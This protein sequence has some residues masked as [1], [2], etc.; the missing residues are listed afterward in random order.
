MGISFGRDIINIG[1][2]K[3]KVKRS[4]LER[5]IRGAIIS[6]ELLWAVEDAAGYVI[7]TID[8]LERMENKLA[9]YESKSR[10]LA[11][12]AELNN[13]GIE[14]EKQGKIDAAIA[15]YEQNISGDCY[16]A[17]HSFDRLRILYRKRKDYDNM[18]RVIKREGEVFGLSQ[19]A[20]NDK[21]NRYLGVKDGVKADVVYPKVRKVATVNGDT[22]ETKLVDI[23]NRLPE[24]DFY[25]KVEHGQRNI[26]PLSESRKLVAIL[27]KIKEKIEKGAE[28]ERNGR[29]DLAA[30][31]YEELVA[32][33]VYNTK[34]Y[35]RLVMIYKR[36]KLFD[37]S[38]SILQA[39]IEFF[40]GLRK[41]QYT[42][43]HYLADKYGVRSING[44]PID[45]YGKIY[46]YNGLFELY[47]PY[48]I[49]EK[50]EQQLEAQRNSS[51]K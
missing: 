33:H 24:F 42:K 40:K 13:K 45:D 4:Y 21:I 3:V 30:K 31:I 37:D 11:R 7:T 44:V 17:S 32:N 19:S 16:P 39:S 1:G 15:I 50:W 18:V 49:I 43:V 47:N 12:C 6:D 36:A 35:E 22:L 9:E 38:L 27:D 5:F 46:Y 41:R 26:Y 48:P 8:E 51:K 10:A 23:M 14:L 20:I 34:P 25:T 29:L 2:G 28:Y